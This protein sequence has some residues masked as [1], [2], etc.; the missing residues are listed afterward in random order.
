MP[1]K[2]RAQARI[3][4]CLRRSA[5]PEFDDDVV[6][7]YRKIY[8]E[9]LDCIINAIEDRFDQEDFKTHTKL[10]NLLLKAEKGSDFDNEYNDVMALYDKDFDGI[11]FHVQLE[12]LSE[13]CKEIVGTGSVRI[14]TKVLRNLEVRNHLCQV[15]KFA[16]LIM[17]I[18]ATN[19]TS[20]RTFSLLKLIKTYFNSDTR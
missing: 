2:K 17:V 20:E 1:R 9:S 7:H 15:Y 6:C 16:K 14:V 18:Q 13:Y 19:S 4:K 5:A 10:E 11:Q 8:C 12:S 3:E